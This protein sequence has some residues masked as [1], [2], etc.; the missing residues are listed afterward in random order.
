MPDKRIDS[1]VHIE[2]LKDYDPRVISEKAA[3]M[4]TADG[5]EVKGRSV[6]VLYCA[7]WAWDRVSV[8]T[9]PLF[10][11]GVVEA[12][13]KLGAKEI[14]VA[15]Q[16]SPGTRTSHS[17]FT[18]AYRE[19]LEKTARFV[20]M[21]DTRRVTMKIPAPLVHQEFKVPALCLGSDLFIVIPKGKTNL[22][23]EVATSSVTMLQLLDD[24]ERNQFHDYRINMKL[25]DV[26]NI[27]RP[28][29]TIYDAVMCGEGQ[30]PLYPSPVSLGIMAG[31]ANAVNVDAVMCRMMGFKPQDVGH[32]KLL[33]ERHAGTVNLKLI[34]VSNAVSDEKPGVLKK[35]DW[36]IEG[37]NEKI[38]VTG[39]NEYYCAS[40][41]VGY[42]RQ[43][44]EPWLADGGEKIDKPLYFVIGKPIDRFSESVDRKRT[45]V[46][47]DCAECHRGLGKYVRGCP[48]N[49]N[50]VE[51]ALL[52]VLGAVGSNSIKLRIARRLGV[53]PRSL[54]EHARSR[55]FHDAEPYSVSLIAVAA[56]AI[57]RAFKNRR[58]F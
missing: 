10:V 54:L 16:D 13:A 49:A 21:A 40:G 34:P 1:A 29:Y 58:T 4:F 42:V 39:G 5:I 11:I 28:D 32:L 22:F 20:N 3:S 15:D 43:A 12:L 8:G 25:A 57:R 47:G 38:K 55:A 27:R 7:D 26:Y 18:K 51:L 36:N 56:L 48:P 17:E 53:P 30:G 31:G 6:F 41:C 50:D 2:T 19:R 37:I 9:N 35:A 24:E 23:T 46:I 44:L 14:N 33:A 45:L 52:K